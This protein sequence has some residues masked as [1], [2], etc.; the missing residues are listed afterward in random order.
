MDN[1]SISIKKILL[2]ATLAANL[3]TLK[4]FLPP[5]YQMFKDYTPVDAGV[6]IND[7]GN[8]DLYN[9]KQFI[10]DGNPAG[11]AKEQVKEFIENPL[12]FN[13]Q[14]EEIAEG[15]FLYD[16]MRVLKAIQTKREKEVTSTPIFNENR[17]DFVCMIG[18]GLGYQIE[19]L[20][21]QKQVQNLY[22]CEPSKDIFYAM[23]HCIELRPIFEHCINNGGE[24]TINTGSDYG[25]MVDGINHVLRRIG[26]FYLPR[27]YV[28]KH[29]NSATTD[30]FIEQLE[31]LG[32]RLAFG[33]GFMEDEIIGVRHTLANL[34]LG[35]K[36]CKKQSEFTNNEPSRP[37]FI[38][39]NGPSLDF[40]L[41]FLKENQDN[42]IIVSC[43]TTLRSLL[44][45][46]IKPDIHVEMERPVEL[47][48]FIEEVEQ[49]QKDSSIKLKDIQIIALNTV[50]PEVLKKFKKPLI[51]TKLNDAGAEFIEFLDVDNIYTRPAHSNPTCP[52][53]ATALIV[54]LGFK[55]IYF[56]GTDF[57]YISND[58]HHSKDSIYYAENFKGETKDQVEARMGQ[59]IQR[60]GN[61]SEFVFSNNIFDSSRHQIEKLLS[62]NLDITAYNCADGALIKHT[63]PTRLED[64]ELIDN[65]LSKEFFLEKLLVDAFDKKVFT[66]KKLD[67]SIKNSHYILNV[68]LDQLM[69]IIDTE[70]NSREE[71]VDLFIR[72]HNLLRHLLSRNEYKFNYWLIQ[73]TFQYLQTYIMNNCYHYADLDQRNEFMN[74]CLNEFK[75][76]LTSLKNKLVN[77]YNYV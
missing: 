19:E 23:L 57:G 46:N 43:G 38:V 41:K 28:Y 7:E 40:S 62:L 54:A 35:Y 63:K 47:L 48:P 25:H 8:I 76:H 61:F 49:Q 17:L 44:K 34:K 39:A 59:D 5:I 14:L 22:L 55:E 31:K 36:V 53:T 1:T 50:Y 16:H 11:F 77:M 6:V 69:L 65:N 75:Q 42:I 15:N 13:L 73:G 18:I 4:V 37:V 74:Y 58:Y 67:K 33:F 60:K 9:E 52:N 72:Q 21:V 56:I 71:L 51:L 64:I 45:H 29:Y 27:F 2:N 32:Y 10:Y 70:V 26:R 30:N 20:L 24:V 12:Y 66:E 3:D 68:T